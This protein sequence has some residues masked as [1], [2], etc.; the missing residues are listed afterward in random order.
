MEE[1]KAFPVII[2]HEDVLCCHAAVGRTRMYNKPGEF[3]WSAPGMI[4]AV[5]GLGYG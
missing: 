2:D 3:D 4:E 5:P 1:N